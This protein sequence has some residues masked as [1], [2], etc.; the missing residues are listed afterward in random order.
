MATDPAYRDYWRRKS[1]LAQSPNFPR[2]AWWPTSE[3]SE[4]ERIYADTVRSCGSMLDFGAGDGK[5]QRKLVAA[6]FKG[7]Y[8]T[9]DVGNEHQ[10]TYSDISQVNRSYD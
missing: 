4:I 9:L 7:E 8:H 5:V 6:G 3:L 1:L 10:H 2:V